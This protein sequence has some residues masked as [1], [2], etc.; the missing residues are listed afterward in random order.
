MKTPD[1]GDLILD[2]SFVLDAPR[3]AVFDAWT[4]PEQMRRWWA[5]RDMM[6]LD[7]EMQACKGGEWRVRMRAAEGSEHTEVG[8]VCECVPPARLVLTHAW[9]A[10]G[11]GSPGH[12]TQITVDFGDENGKTG[13]Q[14][15]QGTFESKRSRDQ[16]GEGWLSA[17]G[18]LAELFGGTLSNVTFGRPGV[19]GDLMQAAKPFVA[20]AKAQLGTSKKGPNERAVPSDE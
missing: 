3:P 15:R 19:P 6:L 14:F 12:E 11:V 17:F 8:T 5:P 1:D 4:R 20:L 18:L 2:L 16:H 10:G 7:A 9:L 13:V